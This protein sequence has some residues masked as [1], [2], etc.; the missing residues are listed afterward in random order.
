MKKKVLLIG[1]LICM[2]LGTA[3]GMNDA[4]IDLV[5]VLDTSSSM[6]QYHREV[7][8]YA[9][10]PMLKNFLRIGDTFHLISFSASPR[11]ELSRRIETTGDI[12]TI[13]SRFLLL[14]PLSPYSDLLAALNYTGRYVTDLPEV[15]QKTVVFITD[16]DHSPPPT[17]PYA[18]LKPEEI[19]QEIERTSGRLVGNGWKFY[20]IRIPR[21]LDAA[22]VVQTEGSR[23]VQRLPKNTTDTGVSL[24]TEES[25][26]QQGSRTEAPAT[27]AGSTIVQQDGGKTGGQSQTGKE[28]SAQDISQ[29]IADSLNTPVVDVIPEVNGEIVST[30]VGSISVS[31]PEKIG[32]TG[33]T[34]RIPIRL[35]NPSPS[36]VYLE[37]KEVRVNGVN[38]MAQ[39]AMKKLESRSEGTME[40]VVRLPDTI[41]PGTFTVSI[42]PV[43]EGSIRIIP[44]SAQITM[45]LVSGTFTQFMEQS[46]PL[47]L[48]VGGVLIALLVALLLFVMLRRLSSGSEQVVQDMVGPL[49]EEAQPAGVIRQGGKGSI[50]AAAASI[51]SSAS[52]VPAFSKSREIEKSV[53]SSDKKED[54]E[55]LARFAQQQKSDSTLPLLS[56]DIKKS[57][58]QTKEEQQRTVLQKAAAPSLPLSERS[59]SVTRPSLLV[60]D[61]EGPASLRMPEVPS[62]QVRKKEGR[63]MLS[64]FVEDQNRAI[65][66]RNVHLMKSGHTLS[67]GGGNSD[68]LIFLVPIPPRIADVHFDGEQCILIPRRPEFFPELGNKPLYDCVGKNVHV[69]SAK[70]YH[71][72]FRLEQYKDP[73]EE[74]NRLLRSIQS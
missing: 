66:K 12:E 61:D 60:T 19:Q 3:Y 55:L 23:P 51:S 69:V 33:R 71:L 62:F 74:L 53:T 16:G 43:F 48:L 68:F 27:Q 31:F 2:M 6:F 36:P 40:L 64:L 28:A 14:Y 54:A 11:I 15:R 34:V 37:T 7:T 44:P 39:K 49:A 73:L 63:L 70:G 29:A 58:S 25:P 24:K 4:A 52:A 42:E 20:F 26:G 22:S 45:E 21:D 41:P 72:T 65:G 18:S 8:Q 9:I 32:K 17:S 59:T 5:V 47:F 46:L 35:E 56:R 10:G 1:I 50:S 67:I 13:I 38:R 57:S 30:I